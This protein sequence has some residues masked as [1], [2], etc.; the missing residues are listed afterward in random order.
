MAHAVRLRTTEVRGHAG[1]VD[2]EFGP[3][4]A[5]RRG[6]CVIGQAAAGFGQVYVFF[7]WYRREI[8][9]QAP[10][11]VGAQHRLG[12]AG[13]PDTG[14][15][16][17]GERGSDHRASEILHADHRVQGRPAVHGAPQATVETGESWQHPA[18]TGSEYEMW[19]YHGAARPQ[20][21]LFG[22]GARPAGRRTRPDR[23]SGRVC[24]AV[25]ASSGDGGGAEVDDAPHAA[26]DR[27]IYQRMGSGELT[28]SAT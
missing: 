25:Y 16:L 8:G 5:I 13:R 9:D 6:V 28:A 1:R 23:K 19:S 4:A 27:F 14:H 22:L 17:R 18:V 10:E 20:H 24:R 26:A 7:W 11:Q 21:R 12:V 3:V 15:V 2:G